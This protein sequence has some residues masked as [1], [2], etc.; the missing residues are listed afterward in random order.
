MTATGDGRRRKAIQ[1][2]TLLVEDS[3]E[4]RMVLEAVLVAHGWA[5]DSFD[6]AETAWAA[7]QEQSYDLAV[8]DWMLPGMDGLELCRQ[9]RAEPS[10]DATAIL[11]ITGRDHPDDLDAAL[12]AGADDFVTKPVDSGLLAVRLAVAE[13]LIRSRRD[14]LR[15]EAELRRR[16]ADLSAVQNLTA[17]GELERAQ[18]KARQQ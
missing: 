16:F 10:G 7:C 14:R 15:A 11:V 9:I 12:V 2:K 17:V 3:A 13:K 18:E 8:L 1:L 6:T 4:T 5:V